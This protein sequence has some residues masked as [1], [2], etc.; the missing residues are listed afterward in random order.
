MTIRNLALLFQQRAA[1]D[2]PGDPL[3]PPPLPQPPSFP[4]NRSEA[5]AMILRGGR[6]VRG[7]D[8]TPTDEQSD[9]DKRDNDPGDP[10]EPAPGELILNAVR[11]RQGK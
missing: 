4:R 7:E 9:P 5:V 1:K 6:H 8:D 11:R 3:P 10:D 2:N